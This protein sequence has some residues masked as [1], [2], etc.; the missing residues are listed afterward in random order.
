LLAAL[1]LLPLYIDPPAAKLP[2][3]GLRPAP[4]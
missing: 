1:P 3:E 4:R 2:R